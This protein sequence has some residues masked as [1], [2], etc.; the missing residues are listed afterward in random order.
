L[1]KNA[2]DI[3]EFGAQAWSEKSHGSG[4]GEI[5]EAAVEKD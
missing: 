2:C 4:Y 3:R 1:L 5:K